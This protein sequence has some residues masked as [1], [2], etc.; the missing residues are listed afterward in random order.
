MVI[1][2][3]VIM[4]IVVAPIIFVPVG[5]SNLIRPSVNY[6]RKNVLQNLSKVQLKI[7]EMVK[8]LF[9]S[10]PKFKTF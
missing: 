1:M 5:R 6:A 8:L 10:K 2:V 7:F 4:L 3:I 9:R